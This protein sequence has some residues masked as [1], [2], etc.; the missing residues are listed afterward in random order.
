MEH[1]SRSTLHEAHETGLTQPASLHPVID[2][3]RC[4][5]CESCV[6][7][8]PEFPKHQV[9]GIIN[10]RATLVGP[11][12]CIGHG[13]CASVCPEDAITLVFGTAERGVD[14][15]HVNADFSTNVANVFIAGELGGMGLIRN[16]IEQ[17]RQ[18]IY[19][20]R[21]HLDA[22]ARGGSVLDVVVVGAGP[23]GLAATLGAMEAGLTHVTIEQNAL[24]GTVANFPRG[25]L[26]M[27]S[28][29]ELP[30]VGTVHFTETSKEELVG[31]WQQVQRDTQLKVQCG[32][33]LVGV[34]PRDDGSLLITTDQAKYEARTVLLAIGRRGTPRTL[35]IQGEELAKVTYTLADPGQYRHKRVLIVGGGD[36]AL[37]AACAIAD[38]PGAEVT[39]SYRNAAFSRAKKKNRACI[40]AAQKSSGLKVLLNSEVTSIERETATLTH[41]GRTTKLPNDAVIVC[42]GG[43][44]PNGFLQEIGITM[45]T[46]YG[47]A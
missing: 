23:A 37:E 38:E 12:D 6:N 11:T 36:S 27:T 47:T 22:Q 1:H 21:D 45:E 46:K 16:A 31:F 43:I 42:A 41:N 7:I 4:I 44:L 8:C 28:P 33:R 25:K 34:N 18:A 5:G 13:L 3:S 20:I 2:P 15:P 17:G 10:N 26:V 39:L 30:L 14:I 35:G 19:S 9:L 32:E 24:G 29:A 40:E